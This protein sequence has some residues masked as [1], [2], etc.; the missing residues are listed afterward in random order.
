MKRH[1]TPESLD[2]DEDITIAACSYPHHLYSDDVEQLCVSLLTGRSADDDDPT[3]LDPIP[4]GQ[5]ARYRGAPSIRTLRNW[6]HR[7]LDEHQTEESV[8]AERSSSSPLA[9][10]SNASLDILG[11]Y[12]LFR[13]KTHQ[14][15]HQEDVQCFVQLA[16]NE[17]VSCSWVTRHMHHLGFV[18]K[19]PQ[20]LSLRYTKH[21]KIE[22]GIKF[23][24]QIQPLCM[25]APKTELIV[26]MDQ[27]MF[28]DN[29]FSV[30]SY[31]VIGGY[32]CLCFFEILLIVESDQISQSGP[33][34]SHDPPCHSALS[35]RCCQYCSV[36]NRVLLN[37]LP[38]TSTLYTRHSQWMES[39]GLQ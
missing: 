23:L 11:G 32:G 17:V 29:G 22:E 30:S 8:G 12:V 9:L 27:I 18:S 7:S 38:D 25:S 16:W 35:R 39:V 26:A 2:Q 33:S 1:F 6:K 10:L 36:A 28:W 15:V 34:S 5:L 21:A 3:P 24:E 14:S 19:R 31:G 4:I 13:L 20:G 37:L